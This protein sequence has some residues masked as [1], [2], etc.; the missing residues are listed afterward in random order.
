ML[1]L[2]DSEKEMIKA[3]LEKAA[4]DNSWE[5]AGKLYMD[6]FMRVLNEQ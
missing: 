5:K 4:Y 6:C 1:A 2:T 3:N